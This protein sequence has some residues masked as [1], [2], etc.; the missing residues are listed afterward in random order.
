MRMTRESLRQEIAL[1]HIP[2]LL[3]Q[4]SESILILD[5]L[6][7][8]ATKIETKH[9]GVL[10]SYDA[11]TFVEAIIRFF[12]TSEEQRLIDARGRLYIMDQVEVV[13]NDYRDMPSSIRGPL[14]ESQDRTKHTVPAFLPLMTVGVPKRSSS[15]TNLSALFMDIE[16][17]GLEVTSVS[18]TDQGFAAVVSSGGPDGETG[19]G[20][21]REIAIARAFL[22]WVE[23][24]LKVI[25]AGV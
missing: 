25:H 19:V 5:R 8:K 20:S 7:K 15:A 10:D 18:K 16:S 13:R 9:H 24:Q 23:T 17:V 11:M 22:M 4:I 2:G 21:A 1:K 14:R 3:T 6:S 12:L